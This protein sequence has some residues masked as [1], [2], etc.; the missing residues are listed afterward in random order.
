VSCPRLALLLAV[1][2]TSLGG[3]ASLGMPRVV[4][5]ARHGQ[6]EF[7]R[8][9]RFQGDPDLDQVG[10]VNRVSLWLLLRERP[11]DSIYTSE[12]QRTQR[13][14]ELVARQHKVQIQPRPAL[15]EINSG[16][17]TGVCYAQ[18]NP[19]AGG[20]N[21]RCLVPVRGSHPEETLKMVRGELGN[22]RKLRV[23]DR[24]P[25]GENYADVAVRLKPFLD[26]LRGGARD[27]E[28]LVVGHGVI[29]QVLLHLLVGWTLEEVSHLHQ[30]NDQVY[31]VELDEDGR[32]QQLDLYT[33]GAD[34][35]RCGTPEHVGPRGLECNTGPG[36][37]WPWPAP[38]SQP[39]GF[40]GPKVP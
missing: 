35:R 21:Q 22:A 3:C 6:T 5:I 18:L 20:P 10:Y 38:S 34:W 26:E 23:T 8:V 37:A 24:L 15:N 39:T 27:R 32:V 1:A 29:N 13:T 33:P 28:V 7:N 17:M 11:V 25:L 2:A 4:Y 19:E 40:G 30:S 12:A 16:V 14:A 9:G 31:R 36:P